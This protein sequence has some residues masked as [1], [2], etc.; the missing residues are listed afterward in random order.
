MNQIFDQKYLKS[1]QY[2]SANNL[3]ARINLH[4]RFGLNEMPWTDWLMK[5]IPV[6][7]GCRV[8][9]IG[10]GPGTLWRDNAARLPQGEFVLADLSAGMV[11]TS[12]GA[13]RADE[14]YRFLQADAQHLPL[15][16]AYFDV[17]VANH[18]LYHVPDIHLA[19]EELKRVLKPGGWL[20]A[21]TNG[22]N[23]LLELDLLIQKYL[24]SFASVTRSPN[25][26]GLEMGADM[27]AE[28]FS[29]VRMIVHDSDLWVTETQPLL[30]YILSM[31]G[32]LSEDTTWLENLA[33]EVEACIQRDGGLRISRAGG[34]ILARKD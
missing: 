22:K 32:T 2:R 29:E 26:F 10:C 18:M 31:W 4:R 24:P 1:Q 16:T 33:A 9:D 20:C 3:E 27:V 15:P 8:V 34:L 28:Q 30:E 13:L 14:R 17:A 12:A 6:S 5:Q 23:H 19:L 7:P 25:R 11:K 21:A